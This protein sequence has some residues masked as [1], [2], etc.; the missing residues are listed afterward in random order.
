[1]KLSVIQV[2]PED[3]GNYQGMRRKSDQDDETDWAKGE[4]AHAC[5]LEADWCSARIAPSQS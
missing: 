5:S 1:M 3:Y 2:V 4:A